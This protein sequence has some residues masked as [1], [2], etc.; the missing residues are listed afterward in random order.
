V[1]GNDAAGADDDVQFGNVQ[2][3]TLDA[4]AVLQKNLI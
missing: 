2:S 3:V 1:P 4:G